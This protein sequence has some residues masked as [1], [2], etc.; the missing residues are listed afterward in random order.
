VE[1]YPV[2]QVIHAANN[3]LNHSVLASARVIC[4]RGWAVSDVNLYPIQNH[5]Q[6]CDAVV[7]RLDFEMGSSNA[8]DHVDPESSSE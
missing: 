1:G 4:G 6:E 3:D 8:P 7:C 5:G 2:L